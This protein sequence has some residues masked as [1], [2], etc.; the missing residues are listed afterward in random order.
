MSSAVST[1]RDILLRLEE[2]IY[3]DNCG[4]LS[5]WGRD[6]DTL[7]CCNWDGV[8]CNIMSSGST[9]A[10]LTIIPRFCLEGGSSPYLFELSHL[11]SLDLSF[12]HFQGQTIPSF[13]GYL[14]NLRHLKLSNAAFVGEI[15]SQL[16]NLS[17]LISLDLSYN[18]G[19]YAENLS[20]VSRLTSLTEI[21]L[22]GSDLSK[23]A[24]WV[25]I[26][27]KLPVLR[28]LTLDD[29]K[30]SWTKPS[31]FFNYSNSLH[32]IK[33]SGNGFSDSSI[34]QWFFNTCNISENHNPSTSLNVQ[35]DL[36]NNHLQGSIPSEFGNLHSVSCLNL[37]NNQLEGFIPKEF[38][39]M[40]ALSHLD[41]SSNLLKGGVPSA[42]AT[43]DS[44]P[45]LH[46]SN[47]DV[48]GAEQWWIYP[49]PASTK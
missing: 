43:M 18:S 2:I 32:I 15:P 38:G 34:F 17:N 5:S 40:K 27:S 46:L 45:Y 31:S 3:I 29:C 33:L 20:W 35:L 42:F 41:L 49:A 16:G 28:V 36:S 10:A 8:S 30:L 26:V 12:N 47:R 1:K 11:E 14:T 22:S 6:E 7:D 13:L 37:S 21:D 19:I 44:L 23:A 48:I 9:L 24:D 25:E 4:I 39:Y